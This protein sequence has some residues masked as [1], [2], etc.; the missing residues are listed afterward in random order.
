MANLTTL[1]R[2]SLLSTQFSQLRKKFWESYGTWMF[3][4][5]FTKTDT[6]P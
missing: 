6:S 2:N 4:T 5:V 1:V 3:T